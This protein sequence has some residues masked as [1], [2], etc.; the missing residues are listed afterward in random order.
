VGR[1]WALACLAGLV[2]GAL[3]RRP[4]R[5]A[6]WEHGLLA[7]YLVGGYLAASSLVGIANN[8]DAPGI[9]PPDR[10]G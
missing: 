6:F 3:I 4:R 1:L 7:A 8:L 5:R 10:W 2:V 9:Q